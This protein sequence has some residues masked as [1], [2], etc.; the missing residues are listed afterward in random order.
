MSN[1]PLG[2]SDC[3]QTASRACHV[4]HDVAPAPP[5]DEHRPRAAATTLSVPSPRC[6]VACLDCPCMAM[7]VRVPMH[8]RK[9]DRGR[10]AHANRGQ[11]VARPRGPGRVAAGWWQRLARSAATPRPS[12]A[13]MHRPTRHPFYPQV[14]GRPVV[15]RGWA[16]PDDGRP[17]HGQRGRGATHAAQRSHRKLAAGA[18]RHRKQ[19]PQHRA[20]TALGRAAGAQEQHA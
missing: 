1:L 2:L 15:S 12:L 5:V 18:P 13:A 20:R 14:L 16:A 9:V 11:T 4:T 7:D 8:A 3:A 6:T 17:A 10:V 19:L